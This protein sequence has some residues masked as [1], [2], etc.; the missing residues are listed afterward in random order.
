M[1]DGP[2]V[3]SLADEETRADL[4]V[5]VGRARR[6]DPDGDARLVGHGDVLAAYVS[7]LHGAGLP[8]VIGLRTYALAGPWHGDV[9]TPL[10]GLADRLVRRSPVPTLELPPV[11]SSGA[12]WAG[13]SPPR[14]GWTHLGDVRPAAVAASAA[15]GIAEV[16][17]GTPAGAG[18]AAVAQ[19]RSAVWS[20]PAEWSTGWP[21]TVPDGAA[22]AADALGF[23]HG[24]P[25]QLLAVR[26]CGPW[27]RISAQ[28]GHVLVRR[29]LMG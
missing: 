23:L 28:A 15:A 9:L 29:P 26:R 10:G 12:P 24:A 1:T 13:V 20:R 7:P 19:L 21:V 6:V 16:A 18:S 8:T 5:L 2:E 11:R 25:D 4:A 14:S 27:V 22:F 17:E 3:V